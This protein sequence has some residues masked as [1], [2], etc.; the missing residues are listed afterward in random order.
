MQNVCIK[1]RDAYKIIK[2]KNKQRYVSH[3]NNTHNMKLAEMIK[4]NNKILR[5]SKKKQCRTESVPQLAVSS[6]LFS[7]ETIKI[8]KMKISID[9]TK[10]SDNVYVCYR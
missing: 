3:L 8:R 1:E 7:F 10:V 2:Q 6:S 5:I 9:Y 4:K